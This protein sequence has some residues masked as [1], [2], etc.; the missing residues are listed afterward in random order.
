M[1]NPWLSIPLA[2]Y[3]AHMELPQV[4][5]AQLLSD[6]FGRLLREHAP[7]SAAVIGCAGGNGFERVDPAVTTRVVGVDL[8]ANY[9]ERARTRF[10]ERLPGLE[11]IAGDIQDGDLQVAPV[12]LVYAALVLEYVDLEIALPR[13]RAWVAAAGLLAT[14]IQLPSASTAPVTPSPY[15]A[16]GALA[17]AMRLADAGQVAGLAG[18]AGMREVARSVERAAGGKEFLLQVFRCG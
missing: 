3:E 2:D 6:I 8:N 18:R 1:P 15:A 4:A 10:A 12:E 14:V 7:R 17:P 16:L 5:Q 11:L 13:L 9:L